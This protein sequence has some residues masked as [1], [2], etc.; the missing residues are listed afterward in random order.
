MSVFHRVDDIHRLPAR[1][2][3]Q[4]ASLLPVY[5]GAVAAGVQA[6]ADEPSKPEATTDAIRSDPVLSGLID[7]G[8]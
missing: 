8:G 5:G 6:A 7:I 3:F 4:L 1:R 2:F